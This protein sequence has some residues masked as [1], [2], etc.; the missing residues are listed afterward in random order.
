MASS[1]AQVDMRPMLQGSDDCL[2][3]QCS[4]LLPREHY[5]FQGV[6]TVWHDR[7]RHDKDLVCFAVGKW[8]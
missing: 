3:R 8:D 7:A 2:C 4:R 5:E 1:D 6:L